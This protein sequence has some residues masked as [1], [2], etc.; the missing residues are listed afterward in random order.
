MYTKRELVRT[1]RMTVRL[2][3]SEFEDFKRLVKG[4]RGEPA[5]V[6]REILLETIA[7]EEA[8]SD[9]RYKHDHMQP[10]PL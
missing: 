7:K 3:E 10:K 9:E 5:A 1:V 6:A 2:N 8:R 4:R